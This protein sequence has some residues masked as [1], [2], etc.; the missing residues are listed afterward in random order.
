MISQTLQWRMPPRTSHSR[1]GGR[2]PGE[3]WNLVNQVSARKLP[4][5]RAEMALTAPNIA[6]F[7]ALVQDHNLASHVTR[8]DCLSAPMWPEQALTSTPKSLL[9]QHS[10]PSTW[11][12]CHDGRYSLWPNTFL[13]LPTPLPRGLLGTKS[14]R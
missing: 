8:Q 4:H 9:P 11:Q 6:S 7:I 3:C 1:D 14:Y 12:I 10:V 5:R 2:H 13:F